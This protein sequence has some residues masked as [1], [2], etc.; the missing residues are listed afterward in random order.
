MLPIRTLE[1]TPESCRMA[2]AMSRPN[3]MDEWLAKDAGAAHELLA[4][5]KRLH[6]SLRGMLEEDDGGRAGGP[7]RAALDAASVWIENGK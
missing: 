7:A 4:L 5:V 6:R 3:S 1:T 2:Q